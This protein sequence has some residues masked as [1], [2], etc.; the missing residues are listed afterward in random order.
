LI[1][2]RFFSPQP[3]GGL[4]VN[5][6]SLIRSS[7]TSGAASGRRRRHDGDRVLGP[8]AS[9]T[10][11]ASLS[12]LIGVW[13]AG[14]STIG[15]PAASAGA[16]LC[17]T[18][19]SGKL[20]GADPGDRAERDAAHVRDA[21]VVAGQPVERD[22]LAVD[23]LRL[24]GR[25]AE[26]ERGAVGLD[27]RRLDRLARLE[28]DRARELVACAASMRSAIPRGSRCASTTAASRVVSNARSA[29]G[30]RASIS[31][32][33]ARWMTATSASS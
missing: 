14:R 19:L 21:A 12:A 30:D 24:L 2:A 5:V 13:L 33:P 20:N 1:P 32:G 28:R 9:S 15:L 27:A 31:R 16:T 22:D 7:S 4:P 25:D 8:A 18:R 11:C 10:I 26:R 6:S 23:P 17:E 3:T 29:R